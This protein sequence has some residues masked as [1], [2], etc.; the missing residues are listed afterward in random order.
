MWRGMVGGRENVDVGSDEVDGGEVVF[1][2]NREEG[3]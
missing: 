1:R 3:V 2:Q